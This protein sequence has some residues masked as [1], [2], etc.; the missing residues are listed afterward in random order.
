MH[1]SAARRATSTNRLAIHRQ[2]IIA[3]RTEGIGWVSG[4]SV[5]FLNIMVGKGLH[6]GNSGTSLALSE[7]LARA[8]TVQKVSDFG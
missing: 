8:T 2:L 3:Q 7:T 5:N 4:A 1:A 6:R